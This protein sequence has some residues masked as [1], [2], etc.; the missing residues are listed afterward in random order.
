MSTRH[1]QETHDGPADTT[2]DRRPWWCAS[3]VRSWDQGNGGPE[4]QH[5]KDGRECQLPPIGIDHEKEI[6]MTI[7]NAA[8]PSISTLDPWRDVTVH[9][10]FKTSDPMNI[11]EI[12]VDPYP[13]DNGC[14]LQLL[15][16]AIIRLGAYREAL[17]EAEEEDRGPLPAPAPSVPWSAWGR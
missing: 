6:V 2:E 12:A 17:I 14:L 7:Q 1:E 4:A 13:T 3:A 16:A 9:V 5:T 10:T 11:T 8:T 15:D